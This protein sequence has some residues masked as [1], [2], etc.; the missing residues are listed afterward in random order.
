[1]LMLLEN[2]IISWQKTS[3]YGHSFLVV[4]WTLDL[5][6]LALKFFI[7]GRKLDRWVT[8]PACDQTN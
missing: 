3:F 4:A 5:S 7:F 8:C 6:C 1:M 2:D